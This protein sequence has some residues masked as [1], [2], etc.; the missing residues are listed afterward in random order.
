MKSTINPYD[1]LLFRQRLLL[2]HQLFRFL[3]SYVHAGLLIVARDQAH[4]NGLIRKLNDGGRVCSGHTVMQVVFYPIIQDVAS[5]VC[6]GH[7]LL[8]TY[9]LF[10]LIT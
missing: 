10:I 6:W 1:F 7:A 5:G 3:I 4:H 2:C 9:H 8:L